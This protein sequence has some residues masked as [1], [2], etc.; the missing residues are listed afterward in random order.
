MKQKMFKT[1]AVINGKK[2][3]GFNYKALLILLIKRLDFAIK[4]K[5][6]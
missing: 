2:F 3:N 6:F 1:G 4:K 5:L